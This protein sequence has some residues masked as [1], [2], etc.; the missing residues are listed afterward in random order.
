MKTDK[1]KEKSAVLR[2]RAKLGKSRFKGVDNS[3]LIV[4]R[5][6]FKKVSQLP[7]CEAV[8][9]MEGMYE[10]IQHHPGLAVEAAGLRAVSEC[11]QRFTE[12][13]LFSEGI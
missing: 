3:A 9:E 4:L 6:W 11:D 1:S 10:L 13:H 12:L 8:A 7:F 2:R 5:Q